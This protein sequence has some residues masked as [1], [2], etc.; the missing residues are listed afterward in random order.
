MVILIL[1]L[2]DEAQEVKLCLSGCV[3]VHGASGSE[4]KRWNVIDLQFTLASEVLF[5]T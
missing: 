5:C 1:Q 4:S 2:E 3:K